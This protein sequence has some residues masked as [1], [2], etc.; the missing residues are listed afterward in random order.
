M[1]S[2]NF[3][4]QFLIIPTKLSHILSLGHANKFMKSFTPTLS[5]DRDF[6]YRLT[7][8]QAVIGCFRFIFNTVFHFEATAQYFLLI[9]KQL[10]LPP[11]FKPTKFNIPLFLDVC[12]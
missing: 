3:F 9:K 6:I 2:R 1:T 5:L 4:L 7:L 10:K 11:R 8:R 12:C